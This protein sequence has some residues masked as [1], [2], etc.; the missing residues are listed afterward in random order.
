MVIPESNWT[1]PVTVKEGTVILEAVEILPPAEVISGVAPKAFAWEAFI[2]PSVI[3]I[4]PVNVLFPAKSC[5]PVPP[6]IN[7]PVPDNT[8]SNVLL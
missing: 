8:P 6:R 5:V 3:L 2:L 1:L 4:V 7:V